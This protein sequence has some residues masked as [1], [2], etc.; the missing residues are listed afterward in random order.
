MK[1]IYRISSI[2]AVAIMCAAILSMNAFAIGTQTQTQDEVPVESQPPEATE[3]ETPDATEPET[4]EAAEPETT[5]SEEIETPEAAEEIPPQI[6]LTL[7]EKAALRKNEF[8]AEVLRLVNEARA[9]AGLGVLKTTDVMVQTADVR[10]QESSTA[11]S[12]MRP[13]GTKC[14]TVF[15]EYSMR[16]R[17][18]GENLS[19]GYD[20]PEAVFTAWMNSPTH[21]ANIMNSRYTLIG[22]GYYENSFGRIYCSQLFCTP[23]IMLA[24]AMEAA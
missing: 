7:E 22:I 14:F 11:F 6:E 3:P 13:D 19:N 23:T 21:R 4:P 12:H 5:E 8:T 17:A 2:L 1:R 18:A 9:E 15:K 16:Y 10:A 20:S 24:V